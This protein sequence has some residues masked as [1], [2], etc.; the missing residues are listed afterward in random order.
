MA[1]ISQIEV[2]GTTYDIC[3]ATARDS[4]SQY[5]PLTGG[6]LTGDLILDRHHVDGKWNFDMKQANNGVSSTNW[7]GMATITDKNDLRAGYV[8]ATVRTSGRIDTALFAYNYNS[9]GERAADANVFS[10]NQDKEGNNSYYVTSPAAFRDAISAASSSHTH[11]YLPLSGGTLTNGIVVNGNVRLE[12]T[13]GGYAFTAECTNI[14]LKKSNNN[15][16]SDQ[17][18]GGLLIRDKNSYNISNFCSEVYSSGSTAAQMHVYN[19]TTSGS[20][21]GHGHLGILCDKSGNISYVVSN[22]SAFRTAI[23]A[24]ASSDIRLK[25]DIQPLG[26]EAIDFINNLTPSVYTINGEKQVGL[27]AQEVEKQDIWNTQMAF[28]THEGLDDWEI[29]EDGSPTYKLDYIRIIPPLV[30]TVQELQKQ[31]DKLKLEI[32]QLKSN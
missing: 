23:G 22:P 27:I 29:M 21:A 13:I 7:L 30:K 4:L 18:P 9:N 14:D 6:T 10:V 25:S 2:N 17:W 26:D 32:K 11:S 19:R 15:V 8:G 16:T 20:Q 5:L 28:A 12:S 24:A 31:V 3:D 1:D